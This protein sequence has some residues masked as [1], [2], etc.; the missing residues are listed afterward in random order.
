MKKRFMSILLTLCMVLT[1]LPTT[2]FAA[3]ESL[4]PNDPNYVELNQ[5]SD[6]YKKMQNKETF[7]GAIYLKGCPTTKALKNK[8]ENFRKTSKAGERMY[9]KSISVAII[10]RVEDGVLVRASSFETPEI[11]TKHVWLGET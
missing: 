8:I 4:L 3:V 1:L 9:P 7:N 6:F 5:V 10:F 11:T 2:A